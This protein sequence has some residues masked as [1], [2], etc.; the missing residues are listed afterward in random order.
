MEDHKESA[1]EYLKNAVK[2]NPEFKEAYLLLGKILYE[3]GDYN[4][5]KEYLKKAYEMYTEKKSQAVYL[6]GL[7]YSYS[8]DKDT[9]IRYYKELRQL[10]SNLADKLF[11]SIFN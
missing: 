9:A 4:Q 5:A 10:D 2:Y 6:L 7:A 1:I 11:E 8:G 3:R